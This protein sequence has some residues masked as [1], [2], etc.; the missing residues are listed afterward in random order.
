MSNISLSTQQLLTQALTQLS[1]ASGS[2]VRAPATEVAA[3]HLAAGQSILQNPINNQSQIQNEIQN[4]IRR[5]MAHA[6]SPSEALKAIENA[7]ADNSIVKSPA[8]KSLLE[9]TLKQL[10]QGLINGQSD[11][12]KIKQLLTSS[13]LNITQTQLTASISASGALGGLSQLLQVALL[14]RLAKNQPAMA[15][16]V[17]SFLSSLFEPASKV[18]KS[19]ISQSVKEINLLEQKHQILKQLQ[20]IFSQHQSNK[21]LSAEQNLQGQDTLYY[22]LPSGIGGTRQDT[23]VLIK[24]DSGNNSKKEPNTA[25]NN[26]WHLTLRLV[27]GE[28][29]EM[30]TKV[31]LNETELEIDFYASNDQLKNRVNDYTPLLVKRLRAFG[32]NLSTTQ[33]QLGKIPDSLMTKPY[34]LFETQA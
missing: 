13:T 26:I 22:V 12:Q 4:L 27:V 20:R 25:K 30:L 34:Q 10:Q 5:L 31:K 7:L 29:G 23:E 14:S 32:I 18:T 11:A 1:N 9:Q 3:Q 19:Q 6:D 2:A 33:C 21:L 28:L 17:S 8:T 15:E 16:G 24:R